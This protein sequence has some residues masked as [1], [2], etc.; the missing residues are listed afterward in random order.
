MQVHT[1]LLLVKLE[2]AGD[3]PGPTLS[4]GRKTGMAVGMRPSKSGP[5]KHSVRTYRVLPILETAEVGMLLAFPGPECTEP[6]PICSR[7]TALLVGDHVF[8]LW[9]LKSHSPSFYLHFNFLQ[10]RILKP[11]G[12]KTVILQNLP[13]FKF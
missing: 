2:A 4:L 3:A 1:G 5:E 11:T 10:F 12:T 13:F 7:L 9:H 6:P 8:H